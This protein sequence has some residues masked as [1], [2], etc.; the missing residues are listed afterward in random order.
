MGT[1]C[2]ITEDG[3]MNWDRVEGN[4]KQ[5]KGSV[6]ERWG[7]LTDD[8]LDV[9]AGKRDRLAGKLQETY[10]IT[11]DE[12]EEQL[13]AFEK[14]HPDWFGPDVQGEGDYRSARNFNKRSEEF[15]KSHDTERLGREARPD[16]AA[17]ADALR[18]AEEAGKARAR[19]EGTGGTRRNH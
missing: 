19:D 11:K 2:P 14:R 3:Y 1:P 5:I 18:Q 13:G 12:V 7:R 4:W 8:E 9:I 17:E 15:V 10:G 16:S 6:R